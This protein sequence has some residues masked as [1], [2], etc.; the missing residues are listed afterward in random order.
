FGIN[1]SGMH[2]HQ[3]L[4]D[5]QGN[6]LFFDAKGE[7]HLSDLARGFIA[8]QLKHARP[9][10]AL[11]APTVNSYKRLVPG[12]EAPVYIGWA[13]I[14]RSALIRIPRY[15]AG[16]DKAMR[17]ELR[18]PDPSCNPY[19]AFSAMLASALDGIDNSVPQ[20][21]PLNN[22]NIYHLTSEE[23]EAKGIGQ[24][25]G[26]LMEALGELEKDEVLKS[27]LGPAIYEAFSRAK[28]A[29][30]DEYRIQVSDWE[31][32]RYMEVA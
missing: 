16:Q 19:L 22:V 9:L 14:N 26:S 30:W 24:L 13:Q 29:E 12:Y 6:N 7:F 21:T 17:I 27:A 31:L 11:I 1:G 28:S 2:C 25:P 10:A 8:G 18:C 5:Q 4:F 23:R 20:P 3:S 32:G 15:T